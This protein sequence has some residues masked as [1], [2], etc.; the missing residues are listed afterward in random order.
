MAQ[1]RKAKEDKHA[2]DDDADRSVARLYTKLT[3]HT[4]CVRINRLLSVTAVLH[5][6][7]LAFPLN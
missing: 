5:L 1:S 3:A 7:A 4:L 2:N 6:K